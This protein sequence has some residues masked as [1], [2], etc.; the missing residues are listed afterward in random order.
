MPSWALSLLLIFFAL[1]LG[2]VLGKLFDSLKR[3]ERGID[4]AR[5]DLDQLK[6]KLNP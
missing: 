6:D 5:E 1:A 3:I 2:A 4:Q